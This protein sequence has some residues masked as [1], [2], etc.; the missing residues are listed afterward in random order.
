MSE[1]SISQ[2]APSK[3]SRRQTIKVLA[4]TLALPLGIAGI[5]R[6]GEQP[7]FQTWHGESLGGPASLTLWNPNA[8]FARSTIARMRSEVERLELVFSLFRHDSELSRLNQD[9][10]LA[11]ASPDLV[12]VLEAARDIAA[13]SNGAF[14]PTVQPL[15]RLYSEHFRNQPN[16]ISGPSALAIDGARSLVD[17]RQIEIGPRQV[18]FAR[19]GMAVTL[20]GI[21]QGYITDRIADLLQQEGFDN[22]MVDVGETRA[23]GGRPEGGAWTIG[24]K[25]PLNALEVNRTI[26]ISNE[27]MAV[28]G[29]YGQ[30]FPGSDLHHIFDPASGRSAKR[31]LDVSVVA[32]RAMLADG[33][34]T[35]IFVSGEGAKA[36]LLALYPNTR[37]VLTR[38]DGTTA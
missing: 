12:A 6:L 11:T 24:L 29:G 23:I 36:S 9:G 17:Y 18:R 15:W 34:S 31:L 5:S 38:R 30:H 21:A 35:A 37:A 33:L 25:N 26:A 8:A 1:T 13:A 2:N 22:S 27:A 20:N 16:A 10:R 19:P 32:P 14:D 4:A 3:W 28:S 7:S